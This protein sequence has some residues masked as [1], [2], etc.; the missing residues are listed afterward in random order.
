MGDLLT[1]RE[2]EEVRRRNRKRRLGMLMPSPESQ[3]PVAQGDLGP[4]GPSSALLTHQTL[5]LLNAIPPVTPLAFPL[6]FLRPSGGLRAAT[7]AKQP[8]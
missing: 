5:E 2:F 1:G 3:E 7:I 4:P 6:L 8:R